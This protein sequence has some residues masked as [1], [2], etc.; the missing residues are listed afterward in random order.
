MT[1]ND[2]CIY[3]CIYGMYARKNK[4]KASGKELRGDTPRLFLKGEVW[5]GFSEFLVLVL[6]NFR[7][8]PFRAV[9]NI[10]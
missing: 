7:F 2:K 4:T 1:N 6:V 5:C 3:K 9:F 8:L 10:I